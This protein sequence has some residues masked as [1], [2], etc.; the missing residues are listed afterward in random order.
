[1]STKRIHV[2]ST[3]RPNEVV[4]RVTLWTDHDIDAVLDDYYIVRVGVRGTNGGL[5]YFGTWNMTQK[6][7]EDGVPYVLT[8]LGD[9]NWPLSDGDVCVVEV[10]Q[11]GTAAPNLDGLSVEWKFSRVGSVQERGIQ[12]VDGSARAAR[13]I[14]RPVFSTP[15]DPGTA[16]DQL[17]SQ[18]NTSGV[19]EW[20]LTV[21]LSEFDNIYW[22][23]LR[24]P[25]NGIDPPGAASDPTRNTTNGLLSF[26]AIADNAIAGVAELP[27]SW[28]LGTDLS[29]HLHLLP[30][31]SATGNQRWK[32]E[33]EIV[34][35][36]GTWD[37]S[38]Y[39]N[40]ETITFASGSYPS[41]HKSVSFSDWNM[42]AYS[43]VSICIPWKITRLAFSDAADTDS[44]ACILMEFD[45]HYQIDALGSRQEAIK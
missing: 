5:D 37:G 39:S 17:I 38:T 11:V 1:M 19:N 12:R 15:T 2:Y 13:E 33:W 3:E 7:L 25:S 30:N 22:D 21:P 40:S 4:R 41:T 23:D 20:V 14:Q 24:F 6:Y 27:H 10:E 45:I 36:N 34:P 29:P 18:L 42:A 16:I 35:I 44:T 26:S 9:L 32:I 31:A 43:S 28:A 8:G